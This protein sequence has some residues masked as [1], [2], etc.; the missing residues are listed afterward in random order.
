MTTLGYKMGCSNRGCKTKSNINSRSKLCQSCDAFFRDVRKRL[1]SSDRRNQAREVELSS[2]RNLNDSEA[3]LSNAQELDNTESG[4][5]EDS[6]GAAAMHTLPSVDIN[7]IVKSCQEVRNGGQID[8]GKVLGDLLGMVVH[9]FTKQTENDNI[10]VKVNSNTERIQQLEAR[11][12]E[13]PEII[14]DRS[15]AIRTLPLP[16][17]GFSE[18]QN[19]SY[20]L[21][22]IREP[23]FCQTDIIKVIRKVSARHDPN[24]G[25][26]LGSVLVQLRNEEV[27]GK[28]MRAKKAL[29]HHQSADIRNLTIRNAFSPSEMRNQ[30]IHNNLLRMITG[31]S[32]YFVAG[33]GSIRQKSEIVN[34]ISSVQTGNAQD[35]T[36]MNTFISAPAS[37]YSSIPTFHH[38]TGINAARSYYRAQ[39]PSSQ[40]QVTSQSRNW[41]MLTPSSYPRAE[42]VSS[43]AYPFQRP[44]VPPPRSSQP[45]ATSHAMSASSQV[46]FQDFDF[47]SETINMERTTNPSNQ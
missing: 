44:Q 25:P 10:G 2:G 40:V 14:Y 19:V 41:N 4:D 39:E 5:H 12:G 35:N 23:S 37:S 46:N 27:R 11:L 42:Q 16:A 21:H 28:L 3:D 13:E 24:K 31:S 20:V 36:T 22:E 43:N 18:I 15:I 26:N 45:P 47:G 6:S 9:I 8:T 17:E 33:N 1:E 34:H 7:G 38:P 32:N 30:N 29:E